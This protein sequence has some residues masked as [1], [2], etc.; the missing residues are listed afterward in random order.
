MQVPRDPLTIFQHHQ[1]LAFLLGA[2]PFQG[3]GGLIGKA[4]QQGVVVVVAITIS[5]SSS[6]N[7]ADPCFS[8]R[9]RPRRQ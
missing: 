8:D 5:W 4:G 9:Q 3:Q 7:S 6:V 2:G 1:L